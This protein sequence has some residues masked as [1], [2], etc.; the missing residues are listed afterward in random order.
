M[1]HLRCS[2]ESASSFAVAPSSLNFFISVSRQSP[3]PFVVAV[4]H[5]PHSHY[6]PTLYHEVPDSDPDAHPQPRPEL[7]GRPGLDG[8]QQGAL[9]HARHPRPRVDRLRL[10]ARLR[11]PHGHGGVAPDRERSAGGVRRYEAS[12]LTSHR[13]HAGPWIQLKEHA[14]ATSPRRFTGGAFEHQ[15]EPVVGRGEK[16]IP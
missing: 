13:V 9:R 4:A 14:P 3:P 2:F 15:E 8:P 10:I 11:A 12:G 5:D 16:C 6:D 7:P 1:D